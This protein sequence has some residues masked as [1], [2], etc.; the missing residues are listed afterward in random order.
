MLQHK[1]L[2]LQR[3][4]SCNT[5]KTSA[6]TSPARRFHSRSRSSSLIP[7]I[8]EHELFLVPFQSIISSSKHIVKVNAKLSFFSRAIINLV[9]LPPS[10]SSSSGVSNQMITGRSSSLGRRVTGTLYG[11]RRGHVTFSVQEGPRTEPVF[12]LDLAMSTET[13][14]K[15]MSS[16]LVRIAL[17]C[18]KRHRSG[19]NLFHEPKWTMYCNG[20]KYG[21]AVSRGGART[22]MDWRV[23]NTVSSVTVGAG[24]IPT[25]NDVS[26]GG[27]ELGE[28]LYMRGTFER[29]VGSRDSEAFYLMNPDENEGPELSIFLLRL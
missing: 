6:E 19:T 18:E 29:A 15:E 5:R 17:E 28:L 7:P 22:E 27:T 20:R 16:G 2:A 10:S 14:G 25:E 4:F 13:L 12:L 11:H 1:E 23:L 9:S 3:S 24:V 8:P 26:G 21:S